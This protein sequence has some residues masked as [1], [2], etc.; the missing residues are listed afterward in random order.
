MQNATEAKFTAGTCGTHLKPRPEAAVTG[1]SHTPKNASA[2]LKN[3]ELVVAS[4]QNLERGGGGWRSPTLKKYKACT[5][6]NA[7]RG[8]GD[9]EGR[10]LKNRKTGFAG[11]IQEKWAVHQCTR[12]VSLES[13]PIAKGAFSIE[14]T[15]VGGRG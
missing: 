14:T 2:P 7:S 12:I 1:R 6:Q 4:V 9:L 10:Q 8:G 15:K 5:I 11:G 13:A 3:A